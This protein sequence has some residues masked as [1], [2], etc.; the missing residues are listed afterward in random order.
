MAVLAEFYSVL[1]RVSTFERAFPGGLSAYQAA[2]P[3]RTFC[4]D[5]ELS[6]VGFMSWADVEA[7]GEILAA[8][9]F[10]PEVGAIAVTREDKGPIEPCHWLELDRIDGTPVARLT[11][12]E[13]RR[14][15]TPDG[16]SAGGTTELT[17]EAQLQREWDRI[18]VSAEGV[19]TYRH[20]ETGEIRYVGRTGTVDADE[21]C[22]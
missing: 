3:N 12:S 16:W 4:C 6:R 13:S 7:F 8:N 2:Y 19:E 18:D 9:G 10:Q 17:A 5:G 20:R 15:A 1:I 11:G 21:P 22:N 14:V